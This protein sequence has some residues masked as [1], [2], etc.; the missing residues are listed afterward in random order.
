M[1]IDSNYAVNSMRLFERF[2]NPN[3]IVNNLLVKEQA[4]VTVVFKENLR[5]ITVSNGESQITV[6]GGNHP[7][8]RCN[9][10]A[11][12]S[13]IVD[14]KGQLKSLIEAGKISQI[15]GNT[16][17]DQAQVILLD[18]TNHTNREQPYVRGEIANRLKGNENVYLSE[19]CDSSKIFFTRDEIN[20]HFAPNLELHNGTK[21][22]LSGW[23]DECVHKK[24]MEALIRGF[25]EFELSKKNS[26]P[27]MAKNGVLDLLSVI[28]EKG[29]QR[30][31]SEWGA[32]KEK[33]QVFPNAKIL[34]FGGRGHHSEKW[35]HEQLS[36][37]QLRYA[38]IT[39]AEVPSSTDAEF[40]NYY[41]IN[42][43]TIWGARK[44]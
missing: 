5:K 16:T 2:T 20:H 25:Q 36:N 26:N 6:G 32:I 37:N 18:D 33:H 30:T 23:D 24:S 1:S 14:P 40:D 22:Y 10:I 34:D 38:Q 28:G 11:F 7:E 27:E 42:N 31:V 41:G 3:N 12:L 43:Y 44:Q 9:D 4:D 8:A 13:N 19:A 39:P 21:D 15:R 29:H 17:V 35:L